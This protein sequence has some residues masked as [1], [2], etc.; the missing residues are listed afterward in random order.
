MINKMGES[1]A[2]S[3]RISEKLEGIEWFTGI[4]FIYKRFL[5]ERKNVE[6]WLEK[7][8]PNITRYA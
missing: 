1:V 4:Y 7:N 5:F 6:K 2:K 3:S 8:V